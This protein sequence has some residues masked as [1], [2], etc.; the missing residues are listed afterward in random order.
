MSAAQCS[1][2]QV[3]LAVLIKRKFTQ[4]LHFC[5]T[6]KNYVPIWD[7]LCYDSKFRYLELAEWVYAMWS[8]W[9]KVLERKWCRCLC[10]RTASTC[11]L[12]LFRDLRKKIFFKQ[13]GHETYHRE[14]CSRKGTHVPSCP[15]TKPPIPPH[16]Y[17]T[18]LPDTTAK[19]IK[20]VI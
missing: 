18:G 11:D 1:F 7:T 13:T 5:G 6:V 2:W 8:L 14:L 12:D 17:G 4:I 9:G 15:S 16:Q 3:S 20:L 10:G 19:L